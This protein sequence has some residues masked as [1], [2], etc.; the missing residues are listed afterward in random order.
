MEGEEKSAAVADSFFFS[1][2]TAD[3]GR[4]EEAAI[5]CSGVLWKRKRSLVMGEKKG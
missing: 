1:S 2:N 5:K 4:G 3:E